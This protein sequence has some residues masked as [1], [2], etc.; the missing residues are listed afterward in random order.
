M[1]KLQWSAGACLLALLAGGVPG[2]AAA[3]AGPEST[4]KCETAIREL[5]APGPA[6]GREN[7]LSLFG[8]F[9]GNWTIRTEWYGEDGGVKKRARG[10]IRMGWI[11][12]GH[13]LQDTWSGNDV[14]DP[15]GTPPSGFGTTVRFH[16]AKTGLWHAVW[17]APGP[18][19][20]QTLTG[21]KV[22]DEIVLEAKM[23][24]GRI[25]HWIFFNI[26]PDSFDWRA[27]ESSEGGK[28]WRLIE[29]TWAT[30]EK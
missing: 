30:R 18:G 16:D 25:E 28:K 19:V 13:A 9:V 2:V 14:N 26:K 11:L 7:E 20:I 23:P 17:T 3:A 4:C 29:R 12:Y 8:Q 5:H 6:A 1:V 10:H 22:G 27:V 15:E 24:D 21:G